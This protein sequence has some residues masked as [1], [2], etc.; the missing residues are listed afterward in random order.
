MVW[1]PYFDALTSLVDQDRIPDLYVDLACYKQEMVEEG[2]EVSGT[3]TLA[4]TV[5]LTAG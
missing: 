2:H 3:A 1:G 5:T 4:W